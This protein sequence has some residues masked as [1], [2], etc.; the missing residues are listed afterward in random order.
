MDLNKI[1]AKHFLLLILAV[2][3]IAIRSYTSIFIKLGGRD[4]WILSIIATLIISLYLFILI[5]ISIST[6]TFDLNIIFKKCTNK[7]IGKILLFLFVLGLFLSSI[8]SASVQASSIHTNFF[9]AT[10]TWFCLLFFI[11]PSAYL[12]S[13]KFNSI[14]ILSIIT[15]TLTLIGDI[16]III[17]V[18]KYL[19]L[20]RLMPILREGKAINKII[21][22]ILLTGSLSSLSISLPFLKY[23]DKEKG[24]SL[25]SMLAL[26]IAGF[27]I[28]TASAALVSFLGIE[29]AGSIF[30]PEYV[31]CQRVKIASFLEFGELFYI[32]RSVCM[33]FMKYI[34]SFYGILLLLKDR[35]KNKK[36]FIG[37]YSVIAFIICNY[38]TTNQ[39]IL[40]DA[41]KMLQIINTFTFLLVPL[42]AYIAYYLNN[43]PHKK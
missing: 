23:I 32:F 15:T 39:Y 5:K 17:L 14:L 29:R 20:N 33:W 25:N 28:S 8:E 18:M 31:E 40:F 38:I 4:T 11:I 10:P 43:K 19:D 9:L 27:L 34:L 22:T 36:L 24:L 2:T 12:V 37:I 7:Y 1:S 35:I 21:C 13:R 16:I 6:N 41:L 42:I 26:I 3:M 30:Y